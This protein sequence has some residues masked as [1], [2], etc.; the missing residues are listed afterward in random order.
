MVRQSLVGV[1]RMNWHRWA[2]FIALIW[3]F[4]LSYADDD[5]QSNDPSKLNYVAFTATAER[6][7]TA[8]DALVTMGIDANLNEADLSTL[9]KDVMAKLKTLNQ[10][11]KWR[12]TQ[13]YRRQDQSGLEKVH[14]EAQVRLTESQLTGLREA[15]SKLSKP[16]FKVNVLNIEYR[17]TNAEIET[18]KSQAREDLYQRIKTEIGRLAQIYPNQIYF[19]HQLIINE[20]NVTPL[21]RPKLATVEA[22]GLIASP[23]SD[24]GSLGVSRSIKLNASVILGSHIANN[25]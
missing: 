23:P 8:K 17:P 16:G 18:V 4:T 22:T 24:Q 6:W 25:P 9:Q 11:A 1:W 20:G 12:I 5:S 14:I 3:C 2:I 13:N 19:I 21:P 7:V 15:A 10:Q